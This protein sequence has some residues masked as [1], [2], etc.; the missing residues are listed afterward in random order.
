[1]RQ[2]SDFDTRRNP[3][4]R[5]RSLCCLFGLAPSLLLSALLYSA[6]QSAGT[7]PGKKSDFFRDIQPLLKAS[8][9]QCHGPT[10]QEAGLRLDRKADA[11]KGGASGPALIPGQSQKSLLIQRLLGADGKPRMPLGF[12]PLSSEQTTLLSAW[13]DQGAAWPGSPGAHARHW[14]YLKPIH[15]A[16]PKVRLTAWVRNPIDNFVLARLEKERLHPAPEAPKETLIRRVSLDLTGLP[17]TPQEIDAFLADKS[18]NAYTKVVDRLL[19]SPHFGERWARLW[20]DLA[21]YADTN[22]YEKDNRRSIWP[23]RDWVIQAF[24]RDM[25]FTQFTIAQIAGD[26]LPNATPEQKIATGFHR[27]TMLNEEGGVDQEEQRWLTIVDRVGT[28]ASVWLGTTLACAQCHDHKYDPFTRTDYYRFFAFFDHAN[29][30]TLEAP[31]PEQEA[32]RRALQAQI[33]DLEARLKMPLTGANPADRKATTDQIANLKKQIEA[34]SIPTTLVMEERADN[35]PPSTYMHI[36]GAFLSRG[37]RVTAATPAILPPLPP[38]RPANRLTLAQWLVDENNPLTARVTVN[39]FWEQLFGLGIVETV[40]DFGTQG[41][42]P[43]HPQLLDWLATEFMRRGWSVKAILRLMV[44]SATYRQSS[45][46]TPALR[47]RDPKNRLLARGPR[48]RLEAEMIRDLALS[49]S[50]LLSPK[51]GGPSVFPYQP[52]GIWV[53]PYNGDQWQ[54][55]AGEDRYRRGLYTFWRRTSPYPSFVSFDAT[56]REFCTLRR[57]RTNTPLQALTTLNDPAFFEAA[58]ALARRMRREGGPTLGAQFT[59]GF[60]LCTARRPKPA[61]L[62]RLEALYATELAHYRREAAAAQA[63][64]GDSGPQADSAE[65]AAL[66]ITANVLLNLDETLTKE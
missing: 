48:F 56:S 46:L 23:Y 54:M 41:T 50:R 8:C 25:P 60:R 5:I 2:E 31:T 24:N 17:P 18:P 43:T 15:Y 28:T 33:A 12:A 52:D 11:L 19:A 38:G 37:D 6:A 51:I 42:P 55:S 44:T 30:P 62:T 63:L 29:E 9:Y 3:A 65:V 32:R 27:N 34:L 20:L 49:A 22:G 61:E 57:I 14:A 13:I 45:R 26:M 36:K 7:P 53:M 10:R 47:E 1:M 59:Y 64:A 4:V 21:R 40:E 66:T 35:Q 16:P 58:R 39:R